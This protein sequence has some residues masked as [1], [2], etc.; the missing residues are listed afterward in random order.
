MNSRIKMKTRKEHQHGVTPGGGGVPPY[1]SGGGARRKIS[2]TSLQSTRI[3]F[4]RRVPNSCPPL[5]GTTNDSGLLKRIKHL[6][7]LDPD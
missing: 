5:G 6:L 3:L 7:P 1:E 4:Y 2:K